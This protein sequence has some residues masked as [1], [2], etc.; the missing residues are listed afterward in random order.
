MGKFLN[1]IMP[2]EAFRAVTEGRYFV[3]KSA[4]IGELIPDF[5][6]EN[7]FVC[8]TRPRRFGKTVAANM[9]AAF[10]GKA[11]DSSEIF[12]HLE[13]SQIPDYAK[14][15]NQYDVIYIDFSEMPRNCTTYESYIDRIQNGINRDLMREYPDITLDESGAVWDNLTEIFL[16]TRTRFVFVMDEWDAVFHMPFITE[17]DREAYLGFLKGFLKSKTYVA[18]AYMTGILPITK[19]SGGSEL[20]MFAEYNM[21]T[22][23]RFSGYFGFS[24]T[25]VDQLYNLYLSHVKNPSFSREDLRNWY[26]GYHTAGEVTLYN[27]RS[28]ISALSD[29]QLGNYWSGAHTDPNAGICC[30]SKR[31]TQ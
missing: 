9:L 24:E 17:Q 11:V 10:F 15:L 29:N 21:A 28:V 1:S 12:G 18:F 8:I 23:A 13:I 27:P 4:L 30:D 22:R 26:D 25:E 14:Y 5:I 16:Q 20:N 31:I 2:Y 7:R 3:D 19:Y 6:G